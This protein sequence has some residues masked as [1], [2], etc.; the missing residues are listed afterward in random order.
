MA[1]Y[2]KETKKEII[3]EQED[4]ED[5]KNNNICRFCEKEILSDKV[6]DHCHLTG[7]YRGPSHNICNINVKQKDSNFIPFAFHNFSNYD[8]H[9]FLK[10]LVDLK[11]D[12]VKFK[13]IPKTNEEY[14]VVKYGCIRFIDSYRFL[15]ESLDE[16]VKNLDEEDFKI[17][18][19]EFP[20]KWQYLNKKLAYPYQYFNSINDYQ[21]P[22][23]NLKKEYFFSK[24]KNNYPDDDEIK[25]TKE[26]IKLFNIKDGEEL[27]KV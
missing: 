9:M 13:I 27:T 3:M 22:V 19:K 6:C 21:K 8:C 10:K 7:R 20:D 1:F 4:E 16:L 26:I 18:K 2:F 11:N 15:S 12:K 17:L 5:F 25:R 23:N 14:I 24:L